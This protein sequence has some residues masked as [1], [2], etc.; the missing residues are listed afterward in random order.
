MTG[1]QRGKVWKSRFLQKH[2]GFVYPMAGVDWLAFEKLALIN[3]GSMTD[4]GQW[5]EFKSPH[6]GPRTDSD[7]LLPGLVQQGTCAAYHCR[8]ASLAG[9]QG[10]AGPCGVRLVCA[11]AAKG[12]TMR[13]FLPL[14]GATISTLRAL[15]GWLLWEPKAADP[16]PQSARLPTADGYSSWFPAGP[17]RGLGPITVFRSLTSEA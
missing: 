6:E 13:L 15:M 17:D 16:I 12:E 2:K 9:P 14:C 4:D 5:Q 11:Q 3:K 8:S 7:G 10:T 1:N